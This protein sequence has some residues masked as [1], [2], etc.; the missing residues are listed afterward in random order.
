MACFI[1][2]CSST[3]RSVERSQMPSFWGH[4]GAQSDLA[5]GSDRP[6]A[7]GQTPVRGDHTGAEQQ[8]DSR[9]RHVS[10]HWDRRTQ[11]LALG[12]GLRIGTGRVGWASDRAD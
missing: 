7:G 4:V 11:G 3:N 12:A 2:L 9:G 8:P 6:A 1:G 5:V 10:C